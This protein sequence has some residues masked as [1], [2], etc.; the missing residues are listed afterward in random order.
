M[1]KKSISHKSFFKSGLDP[2][3]PEGLNTWMVAGQSSTFMNKTVWISIIAQVMFHVLSMPVPNC[4][5]S[6]VVWM[7]WN[8]VWNVQQ[9]SL[10][11]CVVLHY[12]KIC[13]CCEWLGWTHACFEGC[14]L[15]VGVG[16]PT[17]CDIALCGVH[18]VVSPVVEW[19]C[20]AVA[21]LAFLHEWAGSDFVVWE[22]LWASFTHGFWI[23]EFKYLL[24]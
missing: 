18:C 19:D 9:V 2:L 12:E 14:R 21:L 11:H 24:T 5:V 20:L 15:A 13:Y 16:C 8:E 7:V 10:V 4:N 17:A 3:I 1:N 22:E 23:M 6:W